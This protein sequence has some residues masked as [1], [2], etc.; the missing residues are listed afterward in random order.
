MSCRE[1]L[2]FDRSHPFVPIL[3]QRRY[4]SWARSPAKSESQTCLQYAMWTLAAS[5]SAQLQ[6]IRDSLYECTRSLLDSLESNDT[7]M[8]FTDIEHVQAR[9]LL[10]IYDFMRT[11]QQRGWMSAG[12]CFRLLQLMRLYEIDAPDTVARRNNAI[13]PE[14]W[15]RTEE[16]RRTFWMAYTLDRFISIRHDWPLTLNEQVVNAPCPG[17]SAYH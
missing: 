5:L 15:I 4:F 10:L 7:N 1:Q 16:K 12:R 3:H 17:I 9:V 2:Y 11:N 8:N 6:H 14:S 13:E